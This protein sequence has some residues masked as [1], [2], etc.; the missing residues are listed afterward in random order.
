MDFYIFTPDYVPLGIVST[1]TAVTYTEKF[2]S[3]GSFELYLPLNTDN[4]SLMKK[5]EWC[6]LMLQENLLVLLGL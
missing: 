4:I 1:P 5:N 2:Q 6:C 3:S